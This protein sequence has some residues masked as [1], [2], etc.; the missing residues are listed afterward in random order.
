M[1]DRAAL[2]LACR[3]PTIPPCWF[4]D[5]AGLALFEAGR[6]IV[7]FGSGSCAKTQIL[8][9]ATKSSAYI[10]IDVSSD[11]PWES[12]ERLSRSFPSM[13][14]L[15][16][17]RHVTPRLP[18]PVDGMTRLGFFPGPTIGNLLARAGGWSPVPPCED[19]NKLGSLILAV[20]GPSVESS[21]AAR[22]AGGFERRNGGRIRMDELW[23]QP[24][25]GARA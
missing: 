8:A 4:H 18:S 19:Q 10:P 12:A 14:L 15:P 1:P 5:L 24:A 7:E 11:F 6:V 9:S 23:A 17:D 2:Y 16:V 21:H 3:P 13:P 22:R 20:A 25:T